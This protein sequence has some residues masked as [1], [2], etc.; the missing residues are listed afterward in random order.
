M[1]KK[2]KLDRLYEKYRPNDNLIIAR[3]RELL[4]DILRKLLLIF[5]ISMVF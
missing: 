3:T 5:Q 2:Q 1:D 4:L